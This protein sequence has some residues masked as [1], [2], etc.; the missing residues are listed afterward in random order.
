[1]IP[2]ERVFTG[3]ERADSPDPGMTKRV[4]KKRPK[5]TT[6]F[7]KKTTFDDLTFAKPLILLAR[8]KSPKLSSKVVIFV[9]NSLKSL[10][11]SRM[12]I[13]AP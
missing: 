6:F 3:A 11:H 7:A 4:V 5:M 12:L 2:A 13:L 9:W 10:I 8:K 1:V